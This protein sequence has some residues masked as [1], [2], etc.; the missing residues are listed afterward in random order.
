VLNTSKTT[1]EHLTDA[2][3][4][5]LNAVRWHYVPLIETYV[6]PPA[7]HAHDEAIKYAETVLN[8]VRAAKEAA[9]L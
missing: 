8:E 7:A 3:S 9:G 4:K 1:E 2:L 6:G 5:V